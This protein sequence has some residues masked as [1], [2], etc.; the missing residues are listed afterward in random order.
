MDARQRQREEEARAAAEAARIEALRPKSRQ[1]LRAKE[2]RTAKS[3][4]A[5]DE[6]KKYHR[7]E[8]LNRILGKNRRP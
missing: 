4:T 6:A 8:S 3:Y 5:G 7:S 1:E 2:R